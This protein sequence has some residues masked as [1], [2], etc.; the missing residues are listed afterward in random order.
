MLP[1]ERSDASHATIS[2]GGY[3]EGAVVDGEERRR[4]MIMMTRRSE[5]SEGESG[6]QEKGEREGGNPELL[7]LHAWRRARAVEKN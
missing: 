5:E 2:V 7:V 4:M 1:V 3:R 6:D